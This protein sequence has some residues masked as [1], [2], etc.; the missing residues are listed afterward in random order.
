MKIMRKKR[1][2]RHSGNWDAMKRAEQKMYH[3]QNNT[4]HRVFIR[5]VCRFSELRRLWRVFFFVQSHLVGFFIAAS[6]TTGSGGGGRK[7][8]FSS[9]QHTEPEFKT[10]KIHTIITLNITSHNR[11]RKNR[12]EKK[13]V[14]SS[15]LALCARISMFHAS[16]DVKSSQL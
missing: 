2:G 14:K 6:H 11:N 1:D 4:S 13:N 7:M 12:S 8:F 5:F 15:R 16:P 3:Q 10:N 9:A